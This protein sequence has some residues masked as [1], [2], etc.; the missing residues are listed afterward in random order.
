MP[1]SIFYPDELQA[2]HMLSLCP[3]Y[4]ATPMHVVQTDKLKKTFFKDETMRMGLGS[5]K[6]LG[7]VYAVAR[8]IQEEWEKQNDRDLDPACIM[9]PLV[10]ALANRMTFIC[11]SAGNHG[12]AVA[13]G[14]SIFG[15]KAKIHLARNVPESFAERLRKVG[16]VVIRSGDVYEDSM[17]AAISDSESSGAILLAD[18]SWP[19]YV[20]APALV[21][22]G[23]TV[24]AEE[25]RNEFEKSNEWPTHVFLQAGVGG[26]AGAIAHMVR[27][28]WQGNPQ[29]IVVEADAAPC[30]ATSHAAGECVKVTGPESIMG[31]LDCKEPSLIAFTALEKADVDYVTVSDAE[32]EAATVQLSKLG[33]NTTPSGAAGYAALQR[34]NLPEQAIPLV[35]VTE[36][37]LTLA[38]KAKLAV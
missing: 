10:K 38:P 34:T 25:M 2:I 12:L 11:A 36:K 16:A 24:I 14:A 21:M 37:L 23:Y 4:K 7:G 27:R 13:V 26:M 22:E 5:F 33:L 18:G 32:A 8:L 20:H 31:R 29:I 35:I 28:N 30:L 3:A 6:A 15:A 9:D 17:S 1:Q 19:S